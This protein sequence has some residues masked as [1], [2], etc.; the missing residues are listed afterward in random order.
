[1]ELD[2]EYI[3]KWSMGLD[4]RILLQTVKAVLGRDGSM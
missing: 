1:V 4:F 3:R 2:K